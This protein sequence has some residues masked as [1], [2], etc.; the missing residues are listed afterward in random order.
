MA[1]MFDVRP[2][3]RPLMLRVMGHA[4]SARLLTRVLS[5]VMQMGAQ[6][7]DMLHHGYPARLQAGDPRDDGQALHLQGGAVG[8]VQA[9][10]H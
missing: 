1:G 4:V 9:Q 8:P 10:P 7:T 3:S 5:Q 6:H 2:C